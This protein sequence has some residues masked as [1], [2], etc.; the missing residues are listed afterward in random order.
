MSI[1]LL[2]ADDHEVVRT[3]LLRL[4]STTAIDVIS[5]ATSGEEALAQIIE[6]KPDVALVDIRMNSGDGFWALE[7]IRRVS[8]ATPVIMLSM[9]DNPTYVARA[10]ALGAQ[11]Y[12]LKSS[13]KSLLVDA[14]ERAA[15]G[16]SPSPESLLGRI[17]VTMARQDGSRDTP[18]PLTKREAQVLRH[19]GLGLSNR[20]IAKSLSISP[21]TVKEHVQK[22]VRKL[23]LK[24][25]TQAAVW[26]VRNGFV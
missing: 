18:S 5:V 12:I 9:C 24:D 11:D 2:I 4:L 14:I 20:E 8:R 6:M 3:G 7:E 22:T 1:R 25:R 17:H 13:P 10:K 26:A 15:R 21:E 19:L 23:Q 16:D